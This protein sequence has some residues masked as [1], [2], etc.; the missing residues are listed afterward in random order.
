MRGREGRR[1]LDLLLVVWN[2]CERMKSVL[3]GVGTVRS[4]RGASPDRRN[5]PE[6]LIYRQ[7]YLV[8]RNLGDARRYFGGVRGEGAPPIAAVAGKFDIDH[9]E[10][11]PRSVLRHDWIRHESSKMT[12]A[13][14]ADR[15]GA[16][17]DCQMCRAGLI[18]NDN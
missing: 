13:R 3:L 14:N 7:D 1:V 16:G 15:F 11:R 10:S 5:G 9:S 12:A 8:N 17:R 4:H 18:R 2:E 6:H